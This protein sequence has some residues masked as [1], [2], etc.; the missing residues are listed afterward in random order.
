M[1]Q[2]GQPLTRHSD[3][4]K[5]VFTDMRRSDRSSVS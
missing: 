4:D 1:C 3:R 2:M 5:R